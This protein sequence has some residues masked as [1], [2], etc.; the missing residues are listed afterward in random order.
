MNVHEE[1]RENRERG[2]GI[3][4]ILRKLKLINVGDDIMMRAIFMHC[5]SKGDI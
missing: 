1:E 3:L 5:E 2:Y 4:R